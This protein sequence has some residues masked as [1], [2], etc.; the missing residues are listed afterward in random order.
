MR[1]VGGSCAGEIKYSPLISHR[2]FS[3]M[4]WCIYRVE[5]RD[6]QVLDDAV[7]SHELEDAERRNEGGSA[8]SVEETKQK[9]CHVKLSV[10]DVR[11]PEP[12]E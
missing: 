3:G 2:L 8:L 9:M 7:E 1:P 12:G 11:T 6:T 5:Q 10:L 4:S